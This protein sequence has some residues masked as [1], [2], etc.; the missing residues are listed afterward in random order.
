MTDAPVVR[1]YL[2]SHVWLCQLLASYGPYVALFTLLHLLLTGYYD[3]LTVD[4]DC[5][6]RF[7]AW[8]L[9]PLRTRTH[10]VTLPVYSGWVDGYSP[11]ITLDPLRLDS[12][13][14]VDWVRS[15]LHLLPTLAEPLTRYWT[16]ARR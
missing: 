14:L 9:F 4:V 7:I 12:V 3:L 11:Y 5:Q 13:T 6:L 16:H 15:L 10:I 8:R 1:C 2:C